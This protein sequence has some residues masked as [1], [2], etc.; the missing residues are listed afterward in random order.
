MVKE[1]EV[2]P[3]EQVVKMCVKMIG[4]QTKNEVN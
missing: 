1:C 4:A 2:V 3:G